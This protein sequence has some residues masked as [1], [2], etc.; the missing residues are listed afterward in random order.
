MRGGFHIHLR[1]GYEC[2]EAGAYRVHIL[3]ILSTQPLMGNYSPRLTYSSY[4]SWAVTEPGGRSHTT[5][6]GKD[7]ASTW[8]VEWL[9]KDQ[10]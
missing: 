5:G 4:S 2:D 7:I 8:I 3:I 9:L 10:R 1:T 6:T